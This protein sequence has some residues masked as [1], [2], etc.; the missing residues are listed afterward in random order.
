MEYRKAE[1]DDINGL[2]DI[3]L[4]YLEADQGKLKEEDVKKLKEYLPEYYEE[5]LGK[6]LISYIAVDEGRI[7]ASTFLVIITRPANPHFI[8]GK[9]GEVLNVYTAPEYRSMGVASHLIKMM[10]KDA[11]KMNLSYV[12]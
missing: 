4:S 11:E 8:T 10:L 6:D 3:R 12:E 1:L 5:H 2:I 7:V 9:T